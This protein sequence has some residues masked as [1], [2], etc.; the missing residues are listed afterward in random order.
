MWALRSTLQN[1]S[2]WTDSWCGWTL[3][4]RLSYGEQYANILGKEGDEDLSPDPCSLSERKK[5]NMPRLFCALPPNLSS[6]AL[7]FSFSVS[8]SP[9]YVFSPQRDHCP[10]SIFTPVPIFAPNW[11]QSPIQM[12]VLSLFVPHPPWHTH[13][14]LFPISPVWTSFFP[15]LTFYSRLLSWVFHF[16]VSL[17]L[18]FLPLSGMSLSL[19]SS[20]FPYPIY[21]EIC[22]LIAPLF[23]HSLCP[24]AVWV[25][26][27]SNVRTPRRL[28]Q[29]AKVQLRLLPQTS[30]MSVS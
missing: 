3:R 7:N 30:G 17:I 26:A 8:H 27:P 12:S 14:Q 24:Y 5:P 19:L 11:Y 22:L 25:C 6:F 15:W 29:P 18:P 28:H 23:P 21:Q 13:T 2:A 20:A 1:S 4:I 10:P 9:N 16:S